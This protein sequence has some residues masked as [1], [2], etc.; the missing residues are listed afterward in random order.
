MFYDT[1]PYI[2]VIFVCFEA[3]S[4]SVQYFLLILRLGTSPDSAQ[5]THGVPG[6]KPG[7]LTCKANTQPTL[8]YPAPSFFFF[9]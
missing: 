7:C 8:L 2:L 1:V 5:G 3:T 6:F 9:L 4:G